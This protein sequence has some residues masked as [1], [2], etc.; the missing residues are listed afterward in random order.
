MV[1]FDRCVTG[2]IMRCG[3]MLLNTGPFIEAFQIFRGP[4]WPFAL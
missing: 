2:L 3:V 4:G 1:G